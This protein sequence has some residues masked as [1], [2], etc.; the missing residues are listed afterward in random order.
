MARSDDDMLIIKPKRGEDGYKTF[1]LRISDIT[2]KRLDAI[3]DRTGR[4][5]NELIG[6]FIDYAL[7]HCKIEDSEK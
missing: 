4:S 3:A 6:I 2:V 5:R 7:D 1:S